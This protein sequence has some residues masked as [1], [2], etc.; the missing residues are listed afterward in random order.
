MRKKI[1][2]YLLTAAC[3]LSLAGCGKKKE[4][5]TVLTTTEDYHVVTTESQVS[6]IIASTEEEISTR[7][8]KKRREKR[9]ETTE[10]KTTE[11][12]TTEK[13]KTTEAT[14]VE[15]LQFS[16]VVTASQSGSAQ[17]KTTAS[18]GVSNY[19]SSDYMDG[20]EAFTSVKKT[21]IGDSLMEG[22]KSKALDVIPNVYVDAVI[23]RQFKVASGIV[24]DLLSA[25]DL[26]DCVVIELGTNGG[27][28]E[29]AGQSLVDQIGSDRRIF[30]VNVYTIDDD[31]TWQDD[32]NAVMWTLA[33]N[34]SNVSVIDWGAVAQG[35]T[36]WF[37][38]DGVHLKSA[39]SDAYVN[40][41]YNSIAEAYQ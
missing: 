34:N 15:H 32:V 35:H 30:F 8:P 6:Q 9:E 16:V 7:E 5:T 33:S 3:L 23:G 26:G 27:F 39:G 41:I 4:N 13:K 31:I 2:V 22:A 28:S 29:S 19:D 1:G 21:I 25:G 38:G 40:L 10:K 17:N 20:S 14:T 24:S 36:E 37:E 12:E 11:E 18:S